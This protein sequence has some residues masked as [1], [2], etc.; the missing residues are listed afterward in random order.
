MM[1][2]ANRSEWAAP[3]FMI[4]KKDKTVGFINDFRESNK[5][6][7]RTPHH[8]PK[9]QDMLL[10]LEGFT[11]ATSLG[12]NMGCHHMALDVTSKQSCTLIFPFGKHELQVL[13]MGLCNSP[14]VFQENV[15]DLFQEL[16]CVWTC[17]DDLLVITKGACEDHLQKLDAVLSKL[18]NAGLKINAKKSLFCKTELEHWGTGSHVTKV[19][20]MLR[21]ETPKSKRQ[22]CKFIGMMNCYRDLWT[23]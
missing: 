7:K 20:A 10:K 23:R 1:K 14:D 6:T 17:I 16:D 13:P 9:M 8:L 22:L 3:S 12:L 19:R 5:R 2:K 18:C 4:P 11:C 15:S 21:I